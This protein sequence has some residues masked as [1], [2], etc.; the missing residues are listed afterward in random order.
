MD[1]LLA[2]TARAPAPDVVM[3]PTWTLP[4]SDLVEALRPDD[5]AVQVS[6]ARPAV[7]AA[8][9]AALGAAL[10]PVLVLTAS[11]DHA[12]TLAHDIRFVTALA[13]EPVEP[14]VIP[15][16]NPSFPPPID[17]D[18]RRVGALAVLVERH[19]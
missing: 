2:V 3:P 7:K 18:A 11:L 16:W 1:R 14:L 12:E 15:D 4:L 19:Q 9:V 17:L 6:G 8:L 5:A 13:G 10:R